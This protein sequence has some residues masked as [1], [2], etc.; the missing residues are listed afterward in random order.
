[1]SGVFRPSEPGLTI[2]ASA[3][4]NPYQN[5]DTVLMQFCFNAFTAERRDF[6]IRQLGSHMLLL[7]FCVILCSIIII[8][9]LKI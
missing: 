4:L 5:G 3:L 6:C 7:N 1:M 9:F 8:S 2:N